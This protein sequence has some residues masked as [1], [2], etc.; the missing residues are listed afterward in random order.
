MKRNDYTDAAAGNT[1]TNGD[2]GAGTAASILDANWLNILQEEIAEV[3]EYAGLTLD[4]ATNWPGNNVNQLRAAIQI[5]ASS[6]GGGGA[7]AQWQETPGNSPPSS[8]EN[9]GVLYLFESGQTSKLTLFLKVPDGYTQGRQITMKIGHYSPTASLTQLLKATTY[10]VKDGVDAVTSTTN[11]RVS[12]NTALTNT[13]TDMLRI[14]VLDITDATGLINGVAVT[15]NDLLKIEL[16][17]GSDTDTA[18][19]RFIPSMTEVKY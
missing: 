14:S 6:G 5:L 11:S 17:R 12:T 7:G 18:D 16:S 19:I 8:E 2:P 1:F 15:P 3:I 4:Q 9:G 10:L 13:V